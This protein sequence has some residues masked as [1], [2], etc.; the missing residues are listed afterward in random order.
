MKNQQDMIVFF[1]Q[2]S[3]IVN[4]YKKTGTIQAKLAICGEKID[5]VID[6]VLET[7]NTAK[8]KDM[9]VKGPAGELYLIGYEK[10]ASRYKVANEPTENFSDYEATG[11]CFAFEY[12]G[13]DFSFTAPWNEEMIVKSGDFLASPDSK[14]NE[15]YRIEKVVFAKTYSPAPSD[16]EVPSQMNSSRKVSSRTEGPSF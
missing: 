4:R 16:Q 14:I 13:D 9:V 3:S 7:T 8:E 5:T 2:N 11:E 6:G 12:K 15:V 10:F 1:N